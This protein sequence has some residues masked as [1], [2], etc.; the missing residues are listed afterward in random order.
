MRE[1][2]KCKCKECENIF[3]AELIGK[4]DLIY[5]RS[6][7]NW[8]E[9]FRN[10][11]EKVEKV[12]LVYCSDCKHTCIWGLYCSKKKWYY[13]GN[14]ID[15]PHFV[16]EECKGANCFNDCELFEQKYL[17]VYWVIDKISGWI[18]KVIK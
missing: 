8:C 1:I 11:I 3:T 14:A 16:N 9:C 10:G 12:K 15:K 4:T 13:E 17:V 18:D 6:V 5:K 2:W 7:G